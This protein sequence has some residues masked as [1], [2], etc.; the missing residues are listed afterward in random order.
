MILHIFREIVKYSDYPT[1]LSFLSK[2]KV[3]S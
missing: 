1:F 2:Q 3:Y